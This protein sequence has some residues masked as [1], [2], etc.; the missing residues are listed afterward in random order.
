MQA[1]PCIF[2]PENFTCWGSEGVKLLSTE[3]RQYRT[4]QAGLIHGN[5]QVPCK[6]RICQAGLHGNAHVSIQNT[7]TALHGNALVSIQSTAGWF[8]RQLMHLCKF[9]ICQAGV[10]GNAFVQI[11]NVLGWSAWQI[12]HLCKFT[13]WPAELH[14]NTLV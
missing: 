3:P 12:M 8:T 4:R 13:I 7:Q 11:K 1:R 6:Y 9:R 2:Q 10:H 14:G 5:A